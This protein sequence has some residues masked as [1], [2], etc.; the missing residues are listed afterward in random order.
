MK[1]K[2]IIPTKFLELCDSNRLLIVLGSES[3][4]WKKEKYLS[5]KIK[6][7]KKIGKRKKEKGKEKRKRKKGKIEKEKGNNK[8]K[9]KKERKEKK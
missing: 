5:R 1:E 8:K 4:N 3:I 7:Q 6:N 9:E 2:S